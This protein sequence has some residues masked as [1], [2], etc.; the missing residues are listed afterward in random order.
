MLLVSFIAIRFA[1]M[2]CKTN[3]LSDRGVF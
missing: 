3:E 2:T 1:S